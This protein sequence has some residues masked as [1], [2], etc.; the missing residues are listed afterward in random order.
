MFCFLLFF[1][2]WSWSW[3]PVWKLQKKSLQ[4]FSLYILY[5]FFRLLFTRSYFIM[6]DSETGESPNQKPIE[7]PINKSQ[8]AFEN[9]RSKMDKKKTHPSHLV[10]QIEAQSWANDQ[11][12]S[13]SKPYRQQNYYLPMFCLN[14]KAIKTCLD[15]SVFSFWLMLFC[16]Y[17]RGSETNPMKM[18][19]RYILQSVE[20]WWKKKKKKKNS[21]TKKSEGDLLNS[22]TVH[23]I[24]NLILFC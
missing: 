15:F 18:V 20:I 16:E 23:V 12:R 5:I 7:F 17:R 3:F 24:V 9:R 4:L 21:Q 19:H 8:Y 14:K 2:C 10:K 11:T 13:H 6:A 1:G 22:S